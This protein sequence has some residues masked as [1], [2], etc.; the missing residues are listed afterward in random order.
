MAR[1]AAKKKALFYPTPLEIVEL[2]AGNITPAVR[3]SPD[4]GMG[5]I[6]DPC[7]GT[8]EPLAVLGNHLN[9]LTYGNELHP[10]RF[11]Q[12]KTRL[13]HCLNGAREFLV[14]EGQFNV[15][16]NNPPYDQALGGR[17]MEVDHIRADLELLMPGGLG[18]WVIPEPIID[19][20]LCS[21]LVTHLLHVNIRRF[22]L[23]EYDRFK[24]V[25]I[26]GIKRDNL[27]AYTIPKAR[28]PMSVMPRRIWWPEPAKSLL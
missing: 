27:A 25:V 13:D 8:G 2:I 18:I 26:F 24:Q 28:I 10:A 3:D 6:L 9:L 16:F 19:F 17:R 1:L 4:E 15:I 7:C 21:L 11:A 12:A 14:V 22:P 5:S 23:P 20:E